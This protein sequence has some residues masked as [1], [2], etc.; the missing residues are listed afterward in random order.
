MAAAGRRCGRMLIVGVS[1]GVVERARAGGRGGCAAC[2]WYVH[3]DAANGN[4][5]TVGELHRVAAD[6]C[7]NLEG[8]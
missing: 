2:L 7:D 5:S 4:V 3:N 1:T 6:V 8:K